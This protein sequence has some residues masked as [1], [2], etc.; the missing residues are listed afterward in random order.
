MKLNKAIITA[1]NPL[2][3]HLPLQTIT[4]AEGETKTV[5]ENCLDDLSNSGIESVAV[6]VT[7][8]SVDEYRTATGRHANS[9]TFIEQDLPR[10]YGHAVWCTKEFVGDESFI[11]IVGDHLFLSN[12]GEPCVK[13]LLDISAESESCFAA[14]QATDES[15]LHLYGTIGAIRNPVDPSI[16]EVNTIVEKPTPTLAEQELIIPGLRHGMYLCFFGIQVLTP[17]VMDLLGRQV[18][19]LPDGQTLGLT[20]A[21]AEIAKSEKFLATELQGTRFNLGE[22]HGLL[23]AQIALAL[24]GPHRDAMLVS[25][26]ELLAAAKS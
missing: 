5:L 21:L 9:I 24:A 4:N 2:D 10:G 18:E 12:S 1:A 14:V 7:R 11:L 13:Q 19:E 15:K 17:S 6:V 22:R 8:G 3:K 26:I 25:L 16:F 23:K 20:P